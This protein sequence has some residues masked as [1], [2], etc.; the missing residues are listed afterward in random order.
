MDYDPDGLLTRVGDLT[1][2]RD[3][4][5]GMLKG[6][7]LGSVPTVLEYNQFGERKRF[8][9]IVSGKEIF[10]TQ[11]KRDRL[12]RIVELT[13]SIDGKSAVFA[14][15]YD[16]AGRLQE[17]RKD[18]ARTARYEYDA[19]GNRVKFEGPNG[20]VTGQCDDQDR[21]FQYGDATYL[22][23]A[24]GEWSRKTVN[25]KNTDFGYDALGNL[26]TVSLPDGAKIE[27]VVDGANRRVGKKVN[28]KLVQGLVYQDQLKPIAELD[29]DN[30]IVSRFIYGTKVN[31]PEYMEK[32]GKKYRIITDHLGSPRVVVEMGSGEI[33]QRMDFDEFGNVLKDTNPGFQPFGFGGGLWDNHTLLIRFGVRDY[34]SRTGT[35]TARDPLHFRGG[36]LNQFVYA[37]NDPINSFDPFG[38]ETATCSTKGPPDWSWNEFWKNVAG[39]AFVGGL[40][41]LITAGPEGFLAGA[42]AGA[43]GGGALYWFNFT[44]DE[45]PYDARIVSDTVHN[46]WDWSRPSNLQSFSNRAPW[47]PYYQPVVP[48]PS[49]PTARG[50][51]T[52][53]PVA[54]VPPSDWNRQ[55]LQLQQ[56][57]F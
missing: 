12:G 37:A 38:L 16:E 42:L 10:D 31:V 51:D 13:E 45:A 11:Y 34:D 19:N 48:G 29:G 30:R 43:I 6:T 24:N 49:D 2:D 25:G 56:L 32:A 22:H 53:P 7:R 40:G 17:V 1:L 23:S 57:D 4:K 14:Y 35:W 9:S 36:Q 39:G 18:G 41:G 55:R 33:I 28:G 52:S 44:W 3:A 47:V 8:S 15:D 21:I 5:T 20:V 54:T 26:R 27:Y 46:I 50:W